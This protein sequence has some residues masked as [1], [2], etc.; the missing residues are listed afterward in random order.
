MALIAPSV[1]PFT[2]INPSFRVVEMDAVTFALKVQLVSYRTS[3]AN[4]T[5]DYVQYHVN[6]TDANMHDNPIFK[7]YYTATEAYQLPHMSAT[8]WGDLSARAH[9]DTAV[10]DLLLSHQMT[11]NPPRCGGKDR[12]KCLKKFLCGLESGSMA[13][14]L[15]CMGGAWDLMSWISVLED[16][17]C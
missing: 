15:N 16:K 5:Q 13:A 6:L 12:E 9:V 1:T 14:L 7:P 17:L 10:L 3:V 11:G 8:A 4:T 2:N